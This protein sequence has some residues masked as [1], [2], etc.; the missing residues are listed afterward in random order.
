MRVERPVARDQL[1]DLLDVVAGAEH[2]EHVGGPPGSSTIRCCRAAHGSRPGP[3]APE[4]GRPLR[5]ASGQLER[6]VL[7]EE[8]ASVPGPRLLS[9]GQVEEDHLVGVLG[10]P[11]VAGQQGVRLLVDVGEDV[12]RGLG[13]V[14][15]QH[16]FGVRGHRQGPAPPGAVGQREQRELNR[17]VAGDEHGLVEFDAVHVVGEAGVAEPVAGDVPPAASDRGRRW[18]SRSARSS[19]SRT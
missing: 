2:H 15:A 12:A 14:R 9:T 11:W 7:S 8:L 1:P 6:A 17:V 19:S 4:S 3:T 18:V 16:E 5:T 13:A 10:A